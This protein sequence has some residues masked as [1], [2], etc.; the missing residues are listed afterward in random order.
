MSRDQF[1]WDNAKAAGNLVD[2]GVTFDMA[3][4]VF[5]D[6]WAVDMLDRRQ[7]YGEDR[8]VRIGMCDGR[9]LAVAY[10]LRGEVIRIIS[11]RRAE[12]HERRR[13]HE[14]HDA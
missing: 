13:Y 3:R 4:D 7:A 9:L 12:P 14:D 6:P 5:E 11:A 2:H 8:Y 10:T 1:E